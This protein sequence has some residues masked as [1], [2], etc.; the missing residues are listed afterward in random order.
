MA[1]AAGAGAAAAGAGAGA[2]AGA[3]V[4]TFREISLGTGGVASCVQ[5]ARGAEAPSEGPP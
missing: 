1:K 5:C 3:A 4:F 2:G